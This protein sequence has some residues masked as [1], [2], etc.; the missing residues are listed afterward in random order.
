[1]NIAIIGTVGVPARYGGFETLAEQ[2]AVGINPAQ[3]RL[4][5]YCQ[6]SAYPELETASPFAGHRRVL[7]PLRA[8]GGASMLHDMLAMAH[9]AFWAR[10]DALLILGYSGAWFLPVIR[11]LRPR[12]R[13]VTNIDGM[14][15]R[16]DKFGSNVRAVL[17]TLEWFATRFSHVIIADNA[18]LV[19]LARELHDIEPRLI[20]YGGDHTLVDPE[21]FRYIP[22]GYAL[23]IARIEPE[24]NCAMI[25]KAFAESGAP[26]VFVGNWSAS[27]YG[28]A[29]KERYAGIPNLLMI[30]PVYEV[31]KLAHLRKH[32]A[33]YIHGHSVGGTN[34]SLVEALFHTNR[35]LA[36][37]C[38]FNRATLHDQGSYFES[39]CDLEAMIGR[40]ETGII[41]ELEIGKLRCKYR[42]QQV[43]NEYLE[44]I[45]EEATSD[46]LTEPN[47]E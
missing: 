23:S 44:T 43:I 45:T 21:P 25:L 22:P 20:A 28:S 12:A 24:N 5:I 4:L 19:D 29:L 30:D 2:L 40:P 35:I 27:T 37:D 42:W 9:A 46:H 34:P 32:A 41:P 18:A 10:T 47:I 17:R 7:L 16:R 6:R 39:A 31:S 11:L 38:A 15:W 26:L 3:H 1:M 33:C 13:I 14:E 8:N 36:Y